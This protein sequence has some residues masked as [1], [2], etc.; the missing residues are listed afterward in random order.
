LVI[1]L[2]ASPNSAAANGITSNAGKVRTRLGRPG[3]RPDQLDA[4]RLGLAKSMGIGEMTGYGHRDIA[5]TG[6]PARCVILLATDDQP[7]Q[8][9]CEVRDPEF[10]R[11]WGC[12]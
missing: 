7:L 11:T 12:A 1:E 6:Y 5:E 9:R 10:Q 2:V 8:A 3:A 4:T